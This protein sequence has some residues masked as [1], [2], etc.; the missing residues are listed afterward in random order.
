MQLAVLSTK[1][2][3]PQQTKT[4][5]PI[6]AICEVVAWKSDG[7]LIPNTLLKFCGYQSDLN[8]LI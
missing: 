7:T 1:G 2:K 5:P 4:P 3:K 8:T 6:L